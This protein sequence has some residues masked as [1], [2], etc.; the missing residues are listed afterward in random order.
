MPLLAVLDVRLLKVPEL[1]KLLLV[2]DDV[3]VDWSGVQSSSADPRL[4]NVVLAF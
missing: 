3:V 1:A 4:E 2:V